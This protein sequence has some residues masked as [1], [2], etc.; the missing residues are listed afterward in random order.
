MPMK[1]GHVALAS[2]DLQ[3]RIRQSCG[4]CGEGYIDGL[5][6]LPPMAWQPL[7]QR[8]SRCMWFIDMVGMR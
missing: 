1:Q 4:V 2:R 5:W 6:L 7:Q 3:R 8:L